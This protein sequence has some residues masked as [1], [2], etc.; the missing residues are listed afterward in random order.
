V[1][2]TRLLQVLLALALVSAACSLGT[3][4]VTHSPVPARATATL[5]P[6]PSETPLPSLPTETPSATPQPAGSVT[7]FP[8]ANQFWWVAVASG[9]DGPVDIQDPGDGSGRL[10]VVE[11]PG[12]IRI[13]QNGGSLPVPYLDISARV[14]SNSSE[15][16]LLGL[17]FHPRYAENG[18]FYVNYTDANG[19]TVIARFNRSA[20]DPNLADPNS[21]VR[22]LY[23]AQPFA[24]HNGGVVTF[25]PDGYLYLGLGDGG[26]A[27]DPLGNGQSLN[28]HL[29]KLLR[30]DVDNGDPYAIPAD[31]PFASGG[32]LPE[33]WAYGLR[34]P[35][36][37]AFDPQI[38][39]LYIGDVGQ[40]KWEEIDYVPAGTPGG[41]NFGWNIMEG[42][43]PY[44]GEN[45][46]GRALVAPVAE[47][48]HGP[49]CSVTG[50]KVYRGLMPEWQGIYLY[51][52]Y[53][54]GQVWG[55]LQINGLWQTQLLFSTGFTITTFGQDA[56]GELYLSDY[57]AGVIY[58]LERR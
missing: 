41:L 9:L 32:G 25:G 57:R 34:N 18:Y 10:F 16:G 36:R 20:D 40:N 6:P 5:V 28:T 12:R 51:G 26:S 43:H 30:L 13:I 33:I 42:T 37:I 15:R 53:C 35:W 54:S 29:G 17:A 7:Q 27:G 3:P 21:E 50:G 8:D 52:D 46:D 44:S 19:N 1:Q 22:L 49:G 38:G 56:A 14:G 45:P 24:N 31:N 2:T 4:A 55:L 58:R 47:Y 39:D 23:V 11:R 48:G